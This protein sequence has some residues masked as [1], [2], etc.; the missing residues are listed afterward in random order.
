[1]GHERDREAG[2][3]IDFMNARTYDSEIGRFLQRDPHAANYPGISPYVYVANNPL[4]FIDPDG[5]DIWVTIN[6]DGTY[7]VVDGTLN[8]DKGIYVQHDGEG[9][10]QLLGYSITTHSFFDGGGNPVVGAIIDMNSTDGEEFLNEIIND[11]PYLTEYA[12]TADNYQHYDFKARGSKGM[13]TEEKR[14]HYYRGSV[15]GNMIGSARD[16]GNIGAGI[17]AGRNGLNLLQTRVALDGFQMTKN[18]RIEPT[19]SRL[20]QNL[21]HSI[22]AKLYRQDVANRRK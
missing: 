22:G 18:F 5:K 2:L 13:S 4:I 14:V 3:E 17:V 7:T 10:P 1:T 19:V 6:E 21:G 8:D 12:L 9:P 15:S 20:A 11:N 16:Y